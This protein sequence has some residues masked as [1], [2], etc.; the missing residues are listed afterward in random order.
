MPYIQ[1]RSNKEISKDK[2]LSIKSKLGNAITI[3]G[4]S[5]SW[6]MVEFVDKAKL[7][8]KYSLC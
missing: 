4:K 3:V 2:E 1:I 8:F 6:L 5:E 7:Y